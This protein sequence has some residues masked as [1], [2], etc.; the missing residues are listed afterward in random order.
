MCL[1]Q[2]HTLG[3]ISRRLEGDHVHIKQEKNKD[4]EIVVRSVNDDYEVEFNKTKDKS[5]LLNIPLNV[6]EMV[7]EYCVG[8]EYLKF[9]STCRICHLAAHLI[10]WDDGKASKRFQKC[11]LL[12]P[13][14][15]VFDKHKG[16]ITFTDP[17]FGDKY[18]IKTPQ[19]LI[20]E[21]FEIKCS[22][23]GWLLIL[24]P[25]GSMVF[26]NP[27]TSD[28]RELPR[29]HTTYIYCFSAPP[30]SPNCMVVGLTKSVVYIHSVAEEPSWRIV[31]LDIA[32]DG[33]CSY[34]FSTLYGQD[35]YFMSADEGLVS[36]GIL[37]TRSCEFRR[38]SHLCVVPVRSVLLSFALFTFPFSLHYMSS[39]SHIVGDVIVLKFDMHVY[40]SVLTTD[41]V[42]NLVAEHQDSSVADPP[43]TNVQAADIHRLCEQVVDLRPV[44]SPMLYV[45]GLTT[46]WKHVGHHPV[47]KDGEGNVATSMSQFFKFP[48]AGGV[49]V[50]KG[51]VLVNNEVIPQHTT[52]YLPSRAQIPE[53]SDHHRVVECENE[54]V[55][56]AKQK[57]Q[58][59]KDKAV[60]KRVATERTSRPSKKKKGVS[61]S[62]AL[63][64]SEGDDSTHTGSGTHNSASPLNTIILKQTNPATGSGDL[65]LESARS[66]HSIH[67]VKD[68]QVHSGE[69]HH[70]EGDG[71]GH[72]HASGSFGHV[73]SSSSSGSD[74]LVFPKWN[75]GGD[76]VGSSSLRGGG[77]DATQPSL[78]VPTLKLTTHSILNDAE[79]Y[80]DMMIHLATPAVHDQQS[81]LSDHQAL[82]HSWF[83]L[84]RGALAQ[85][86]FLQQY[87]ALSD[88]Y[89]DLY[90]SHRSCG[91]VSDRLTETQNQLV[92]AIRNMNKL[93]DDHKNLQQEHL[94]CTG[95]E[96]ALVEKLVVVEKEKDDLL[97]KNREQE[98]WIKQLEEELASKTSSLTSAESS[99]SNLR[100]DL[101]CLTVDLSQAEIKSLTNVFNMAAVVEWSKGVKAALSEKEA[102]AFLATAVDYDPACK[103]TF[104][105]WVYPEWQRC[106]CWG[107]SVVQRVFEEDYIR[108]FVVCN[109]SVKTSF[110]ESMVKHVTWPLALGLIRSVLRSE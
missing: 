98:E 75:P 29:I 36:N 65:A 27:F 24:K 1:E 25:S 55:L 41:E 3:F 28:I 89:S 7:M 56:A 53:K 47:F 12:S 95:K 72:Q 18:F 40:T 49:R 63:D 58:A 15:I 44:H 106:G 2:E 10:Q 81:H 86:D 99:V 90:D 51:S 80:R 21:Y 64:E 96:A 37:G 74:R 93:S 110:A 11:S 31:V 84:G 107:C 88:D 8:V 23:Y 71:Q 67:S 73:V 48:M 94:G 39:G 19:E 57:A 20:C 92:N 82:Q 38:V 9:C 109:V 42:N 13:W 101:E 105:Y 83:E 43:P 103:D 77:G 100:G 85:I 30:T 16:I 66:Q 59:A 62:F 79:S 22:R 5:H 14:L 70:D 45:F 76:G 60:G 91:D 61:L 52:P 108:H 6:L 97:Y 26:Y 17:L 104:M 54:R 68:T 35:L 69:P 46:I 34:H 50:G 102:E 32:S 78:F 4:D 87:E 33:L